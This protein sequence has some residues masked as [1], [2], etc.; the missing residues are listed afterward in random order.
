MAHVDLDVDAPQ[1]VI[2]SALKAPKADDIQPPTG[3][4]AGTAGVSAEPQR[5]PKLLDRIPEQQQPEIAAVMRALMQR[6]RGHAR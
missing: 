5:I 2:C 6:S 3:S 4:T 1:Q